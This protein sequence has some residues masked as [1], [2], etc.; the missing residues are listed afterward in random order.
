MAIRVPV[1]AALE[2]VRDPFAPTAPGRP[3]AVVPKWRVREPDRPPAA[4]SALALLPILL[5]TA[6]IVQSLAESRL[7]VEYGWLLLA[8][9]RSRRRAKPAKAMP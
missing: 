3:G 2:P 1:A 6:L 7:L 8:C 5:L 4:A 9:W